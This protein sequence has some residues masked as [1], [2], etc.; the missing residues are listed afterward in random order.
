AILTPTPDV[1]NQTLMALPMY[2][3]YEVGILAARIL[4][5]KPAVTSQEAVEEI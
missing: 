2:L 3:L 1:F 4:I 5:R